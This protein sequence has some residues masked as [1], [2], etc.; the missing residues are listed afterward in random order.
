M[1]VVVFLLVAVALLGTVSTAQRGQAPVRVRFPGVD[2]GADSLEARKQAQLATASQFNVFHEFHFADKVTDSGITFRHHIVED[3]GKHYKMAHYDHGNGVAAADVDGD[4]LVDIYFV[5]QIG[6]NELWKNMGGGRFR[7]ITPGSGVAV[8]DRIGVTASFADIDNDGDQDLFVT[9]V[10]GGNLLF[11]NDGRGRFK[12]ITAA[13]GVG[14]VAHSSG[15]VFFDY[16]HD[17]LLDLLVCNVGKYTSDV[18]GPDGAYIALPDAFRGFV[19]PERFEHP[20]LYRNMGHNVFNDVTAQV[21]L[22]FRGWSGDAIV[23]DLN[24]DGWPD[25]FMLVM[26]GSQHYYENESGRTFVDKTATYFPK[27]PMGAMGIASL[28]FD[29]DGRMDL[30]LTDMHADMVAQEVGPP[31]EKVKPIPPRTSTPI[32]MTSAPKP[33]APMAMGLGTFSDYVLGNALYHNNGPGPFEEVSDR[34]GVETYWPWGTSVGDVNADGWTDIF[35]TAGMNFPFRYGI[36]SLLLNDLGRKFLDAEFMLGIEP[37]KDGRTSTSWHEEDCSSPNRNLNLPVQ[38][39]RPGPCQG[40]TGKIEVMA[41]LAS[42]S[43]VIF[44]LDNDGDLD[45]VT[46]DFNSAPQ[47]LISDLSQQKAL[48]WINLNLIGTASNR[49]GLGAMV[50]VVAGKQVYTRYV[51]G[52]SGYLSQSVLPLYFGLGDAAAIDRIEIDWPS[53]RKQVERQGLRVNQALTLTEP[54]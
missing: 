35:I 13:A 47:V 4:G 33:G 40:H 2:I 39:G 11:E 41:T 5:S 12:D 24:R 50:R 48:H 16:D 54:K 31:L 20:V 32:G 8:A 6:G 3:A 27:T 9:T 45:I 28:D 26:A 7:N 46:S 19:F 38:E 30:F 17:G 22:T 51:D 36:N 49:S 1:R 42:R 43:S 29:N 23:T 10:R 34:L 44:D 18:K 52:K 21:G 25:V 14:L 53:G 37:R 15:A